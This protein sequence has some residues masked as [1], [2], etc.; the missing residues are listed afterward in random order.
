MPS[1]W[2]SGLS[3]LGG[4]Q[5]G[6][7]GWAEVDRAIRLVLSTSP[8]PA[9]LY[10]RETL[11]FVCV[12]DAAVERY[13]YDE[14]EFLAMRV[15]D[16][17]PFE[18]LVR[19]HDPGRQGAREELERSGPWRHITASGRT[20]WV[21]VA[22]RL[23]EWEGHDAV[24][25]IASELPSEPT[26]SS[27]TV[28]VLSHEEAFVRVMAERIDHARAIGGAAAVLLIELA[29]LERMHAVAGA[30]DARAVLDEALSSVESSCSPTDTLALLGHTRLGVACL[31]PSTRHLLDEADAVERSL[32]RPRQA[33]DPRLLERSAFVGVAV[34]GPDDPPSDADTMVH[35]AGVALDEAVRAGRGRHLVVFDNRLRE[36]ITAEFSRDQAIR[37]A[38]A[39]E[40]FFLHYQPVV[41]TETGDIHGYEALLRWQRPGGDVEG[42]V[43]VI[44]LAEENGDIVALG[45]FVR[46]RALA[47][48]RRLLAGSPELFLAINLSPY[49][50][51]HLGLAAEVEE[52][53]RGAG[54]SPGQLC[55]ELTET[56]LVTASDDFWRFQQLL[57]LKRIGCRIAIDDFGTGYSALSYLK[58]LPVDVVKIDRSFVADLATSEADTVLVEAITR[59]AHALGLSLVAEGVETETD[60]QILKGLGVDHA[61]GFLLGRPAPLRDSPES[62]PAR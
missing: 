22:T 52:L 8:V 50:L 54:V 19:G 57:D 27:R 43:E 33:D 7:T 44:A 32:R 55:F 48:C 29:G 34:V 39:A 60:L 14:G 41:D 42:P 26:S 49:E 9:W 1:P 30:R 47:D 38:L 12:N 56:A 11:R 45:A 37:Q 3:F 35:D 51:D 15:T 40:D 5:S 23:V 36:R 16:I 62:A 17:R 53:C 31:A 61:Q 18:D 21:D 25:V 2:R 6:N 4:D 59:L 20:L 13:G 28:P 10:D 58:K 46:R 24:L